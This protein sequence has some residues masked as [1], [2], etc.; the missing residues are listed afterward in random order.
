M[1]CRIQ[2]ENSLK[3]ELQTRIVAEGIDVARLDVAQKK[4]D[5]IN[6]EYGHTIIRVREGD[7]TN[8]IGITIP[9]E[10]IDQQQDYWETIEEEEAR[11]VQVEDAERAG[12]EYS[13]RYMFQQEEGIAPASPEIIKQMKVVAEKMGISIQKMSDYLKGNPEIQSTGIN[14]LADLTRKTIAIAEGKEDV[15]LT[16]EV[17]HIATTMIEQVNPKM[18][19]EMLSKIG[20]FDIYKQTL[21]QYRNN[22]NYQLSN[23]K[24]DIRK[25]KKEA[26]DKLIT[27]LI[28]NENTGDE[29]FP[30]LADEESRS[31]VRRWW[32]K[33]MDEIRALYKK[34][35]IDI[36]RE[37]A[38]VIVRGEVENVEIEGETFF[39]LSDVQKDLQQKL[40]ATDENIRKVETEEKADPLLMDESEATNWY[41]RQKDDG[42]WVKVKKRVTDRVK[43]W[44]R[45]KFG[46]KEFTPEEKAINEFKREHGVTYHGF[47]EEIHGRYFNPDG[48]RKTKV[49]RRPFIKDPIEERI[50]VKLEQYFVEL[51]DSFSKDGKQPLVFAE[52]VIYDAKEDEAGTIDLMIVE[53]DGKVNIFDWKFMSVSAGAEDVAWYKKGAYNVQLGRYKNI[54]KNVYGVKSIGMNRA[55]PIIMDIKRQN[56]KDKKSPLKITGIKIGSVNAQEIEDLTLVPVSEETEFTGEQKLDKLIK[57]L[58]DVLRQVGKQEVTTE[59][60]KEFKSDRLNALQKAVRMLQSQSVINPLIEVIQDT[61]TEGTMIMDDYNQIY[62]GKDSKSSEFSKQ[63]LSDFAEQMAEYLDAAEVFANITSYIEDLIFKPVMLEEAKTPE[64]V[65]DAK[66]RKKLLEDI[67]QEQAIIKSAQEEIQ[68]IRGEFVDKFVGQRNNIIGLLLPEAT[69]KWLTRTYS[70][71]SEIPLQ[72]VKL[73]QKLVENAEGLASRTALKEINSIM[74]LRKRLVEKGNVREQIKKIQQKNQDNKLV[75]KLIHKYSRDFYDQVEENAKEGNRDKKWLKDNI[76]VEEYKKEAFEIMN[77]KI[78]HLKRKYADNDELREKLILDEKKKWD[79]DRFDFNGWNNYVIKRHPLTKWYSEEYKEIMKDQD[80]LDLYNLITKINNRARDVG[81]IQ[82]KVATTFLPFVRKSLAEQLSWSMDI[83]AIKNWSNS[84]KIDASTVGQGKINELNQQLEYGLPKYFTYD[85]TRTEEGEN[86]YSDV[87]E[88]LFKNLIMYTSHVEKYV[89]MSEIEGQI[90]AIKDVEKFKEHHLVSNRGG[91]IAFNE[92]GEPETEKGNEENARLYD[93]FMR[94]IFYEQKMPLTTDDM[95]ISLGVMEYMK[96]AINKV[97][98][99]Q[100]FTPKDKPSAISLVKAMDMANRAFSIKTLGFELPSG[101]VNAFGGIIQTLTQAGQYFKQGE[102]LANVGKLIKNEFINDDEREMFI[103]LI[104]NFMPL[105]E[106]PSYELMKKAGL[107]T[108]TRTNFSDL[109][110]VFMRKPELHLE[111][112]IFLT[113]LDNMMVENGKIISIREYVKKKNSDRYNS[114]GQYKESKLKIE[115]EV[116]ELKK[117]RSISAIKKLEDGKLVIPGLDLSNAEELQRLTTLARRISRNATGGTSESDRNRASMDIWL[118]SMMVFKNWIPKLVQTR[119]KSLQQVSD[120]FSVIINEDGLS[121]GDKYDIGRIRLWFYTMGTSVRDRSMNVRNIILMNDKGLEVLDKMYSDM[122]ESYYQR[123]GKQ[124]T[125]SRDD[126]YDMVRNNL[127]NQMKELGLLLSLFGAGMAMGMMEPP[128]DADKSTKN[129]YRFMQKVVD[130]F[131]NELSFFYNPLEFQRLLSG[132]A[133]PAIGILNDI[134]KFFTHVTMEWTGYDITNPTLSMDEVREKAQPIKYMMRMFPVTKSAVTYGAMLSSDF[135]K[136]FDVTIPKTARR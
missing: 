27:E 130:K 54:L 136:E 74:E 88:D 119:F 37:A 1:A 128:E 41:E 105:K 116:N 61:R 112:S 32:G 120:D 6:K 97:A 101:M 73:L 100:V 78:E 65:A 90:K 103:Q 25:I 99:H 87:S 115:E 66:A 18:I 13:D 48:T 79:I 113:L 29:Y 28:V 63:Q 85:F 22:K 104:D 109:L 133:F 95:P 80:L 96:R 52:K 26:V 60:E 86:D 4:A 58:N 50:Y 69:V 126:F 9:K 67:R 36:F 15:A 70:T 62:K 118:R 2:I 30:E 59:E 111:K 127:S 84:L 33:L 72:S 5:A 121:E 132:S 11:G 71:A 134:E 131:V 68:E 106:D 56:F 64:E 44:Y 57:K 40:L 20:N 93:E 102:F 43:Q 12:V 7:T 98:G 24:P 51:V 31:L 21:S 125:M 107:S 17:V 49:D 124:F 35:G 135:A 46:N 39:Q 108:L 89:Y 81:Y 114:A 53:E 83:S 3:N 19:T 82:N 94:G 91:G 129:A 122:A 42:T 110:M 34:A 10:W 23:G 76:D 16:E 55:I 75:N 123:T 14:A 117:T 8:K 92:E 77:R 45:N 38:G 47:F